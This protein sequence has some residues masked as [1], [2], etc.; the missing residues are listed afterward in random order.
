LQT[1]FEEHEIVKIVDLV[2]ER[3]KPILGSFHNTE[4]ELL[5]LKEAANF[6]KKSEQQLYQWVHQ[7]AHKRS[8]FPYRKVGRTLMFSKNELSSW[9][10]KH[11]RPLEKS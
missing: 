10:K 6:L 11:G 3:L 5:T 9:M 2:V 8:D 7:S 4:D 1:H